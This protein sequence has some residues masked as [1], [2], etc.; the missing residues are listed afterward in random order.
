[1]SVGHICLVQTPEQRACPFVDH[2][3]SPAGSGES[4]LWVGHIPQAVC[5]LILAWQV[6]PDTPVALA[7]NRDE[8]LDRDSEPPAARDWETPVVAP[9]DGAA[10]GTWL[11]YN[12]HGLLVTITNRWD[13]RDIDGARS[14]GLLVRDALAHESAEA[15]ARFVERELDARAY[16]GFHLLVADSRAALLVTFDGRPQVRTLDPGVH[17]VVNVGLDGDYAIPEDRETTSRAQAENADAVRT[18]LQPEPG[19]DADAWLDRAGSA[20]GDHRYGACIHGDG[21]GTRSA[22]LVRLGGTVRFDYAD[23]P[24]C[25][26]PYKRVTAAVAPPW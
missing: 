10:G 18:A 17:V 26:T 1:M 7:A 23:G 14:R 16:E 2:A 12:R 13:G 24:P 3:P 8:R 21:F 4:V 19:E 25:E 15:A 11:G 5:T 20:L 6:F 22:S 9:K